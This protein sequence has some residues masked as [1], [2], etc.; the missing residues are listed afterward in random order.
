MTN[1][2][3][4]TNFG[5]D[6]SGLMASVLTTTTITT[7]ISIKGCI[8]QQQTTINNRYTHTGFKRV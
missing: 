2:V 6:C 1:V 7:I 8:Q 4:G 3:P 5:T